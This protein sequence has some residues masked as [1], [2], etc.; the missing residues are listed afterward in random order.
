MYYRGFGVAINYQ[1]TL[2]FFQKAAADNNDSVFLFLDYFYENGMGF[3]KDYFKAFEYYKKADDLNNSNVKQY[4]IN[5][6]K[7][8]I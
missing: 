6:Q 3:T 7:K 2:E 5:L 1:K 8:M 4:L